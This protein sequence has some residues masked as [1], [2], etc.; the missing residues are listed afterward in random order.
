MCIVLLD[1]ESKPCKVPIATASCWLL[2]T[3]CCQPRWGLAVLKPFTSL[4]GFTHDSNNK[5]IYLT[6]DLIDIA[7]QF[8]KI[9]FIRLMAVPVLTE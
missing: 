4:E 6:E 3:P 9:G 2:T 7:K 1:P 8:I 5:I